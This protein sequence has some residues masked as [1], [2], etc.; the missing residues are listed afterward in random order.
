MLTK[1]QIL[2]ENLHGL[3]KDRT[4]MT[5]EHI[6]LARQFI[7]E[8]READSKSQSLRSERNQLSKKA[9]K[10]GVASVKERIDQIDAELAVLARVTEP[11]LRGFP[12]IPDP[13]VP[14]GTDERD[15]VEI[16][17]EDN[18][19]RPPVNDSHVTVG[20]KLGLNNEAGAAMSGSRF[21]VLTGAIAKLERVLGQWMLD[22]HVSNGWSEVSTPAI[23]NEKALVN[24]GQLPKF[25]DDLFKIEGRKQYL[26]PT[27]EVTLTNMFADHLFKSQPDIKMTALTPCF[28]SEAGSAGK[29]T[30]GL[31]R[32]H[33][34]NKVELV[35][36]TTPDKSNERHEEMVQAA[37]NILRKLELPFRTVLLCKGDMG[38]SAQKTYDLEVFLP[39]VNKFREISSV[40]NCGQFQAVRMG[41]RYKTKGMSA[42]EYV[43]T[44][45]GSGVAVG[46]ALVAI[47]EN[48][49]R[50]GGLAIPTALQGYM[51][52]DFIPYQ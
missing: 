18:G 32:Q 38:F 8:H 26:I 20:K 15:N 12:N 25:A 47:L 2:N 24:T 37:E 3:I 16:R 33:Q 46:R 9:G 19:A 45:N 10:D 7:R 31:I 36:I 39:S 51:G 11:D 34:F 1:S 44:L 4:S 21:T 42:S 6:E 22:Q 5:A 40:S 35:S 48:Y 49:Q 23:V 17:R 13:T 30:M 29:D 27:S 41:T 52:T 28:R 14:D 43:H 50:E